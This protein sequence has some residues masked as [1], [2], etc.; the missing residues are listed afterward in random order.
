MEQTDSTLDC[1]RRWDITDVIDVR[2]FV[3]TRLVVKRSVVEMRHRNGRDNSH[4]ELEDQM[5][6]ECG[7][8]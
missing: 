5:N 7:E 2:T 3:V 6:S 4:Y 8:Q 1:V